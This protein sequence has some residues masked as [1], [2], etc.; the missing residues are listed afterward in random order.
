MRATSAKLKCGHAV[1]ITTYIAQTLRGGSGAYVTWKKPAAKGK[2]PA[3]KRPTRYRSDKG[4]QIGRR[5]D[6]QFQACAAAG[7]ARGSGRR[8]RAV[9]RVLQLLRLKV[10]STQAGVIEPSLGPVGIKTRLDGLAVG[11]A[12]ELV[13]IELKS[14]Q[15]SYAEHCATYKMPCSRHPKMLNGLPNSE[16]T[17]HQLQTGFG[18]RALTKAHAR[19]HAVAGIVIVSCSD[20]RAAYY[21]VS[22]EYTRTSCFAVPSS[23]PRLVPAKP[24]R[25]VQPIELEDA[26]IA[27]AIGTR[28]ATLSAD[29]CV[30]TVTAG[31]GRKTVYCLVANSGAK[32]RAAGA[33][34][35]LRHR[36]ATARMLLVPARGAYRLVPV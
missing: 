25:Q 29:R 14:T 6:L 3:A 12:G 7:H 17:S 8:I 36:S 9:F 35:L 2:T 28:T 22:P 19:G 1:G 15:R 5:L 11:A 23:R 33:R 27:A 20:G 30:A 10:V 4:I 21:H 31:K 24:N 26:R 34:R 32:S 13:V 18:M 16:Y